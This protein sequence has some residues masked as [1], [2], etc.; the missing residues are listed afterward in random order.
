MIKTVQIR[1]D[2]DFLVLE[3]SSMFESNHHHIHPGQVYCAERD[4]SDIH[5]LSENGR[6]VKTI[7]LFGF[8]PS[9]ISQITQG[10]ND[11]LFK[12]RRYHRLTQTTT[13]IVE[14]QKNTTDVISESL[15]KI[16]GEGIKFGVK[17]LLSHHKK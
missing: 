15:G 17:S 1:D 8:N 5:L 14:K 10:I 12:M 7:D 2:G 3:V 16:I 9:K 4:W 6:I 11:Y 13:I